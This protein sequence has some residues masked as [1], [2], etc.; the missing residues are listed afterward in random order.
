M[1]IIWKSGSLY[2]IVHLPV[3]V[4]LNTSETKEVIVE[5]R[6]FRRIEQA[7]LSKHL[8]VVDNVDSKTI[9]C[10]HIFSSS[11]NTPHLVKKA[12]QR[13][14]SLRK[15]KNTFKSLLNC[16]ETTESILL[17]I[18]ALWY[19]SLTAQVSM[20]TPR[21]GAETLNKENFIKNQ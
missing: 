15:L 12:Q 4:R 11:L 10:T 13:L 18:V 17:L 21:G 3:G 20:D 9:L 16:S 2:Q 7:P 5:K 8:E 1:S 19:G 6:K 14:L